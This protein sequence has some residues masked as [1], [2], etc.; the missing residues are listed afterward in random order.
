MTLIDF[1]FPKLR[2]CK[3]QS[4]KCLK[5][6]PSEY[7]STR[8]IADVPK[9]CEICITGSFSYYLIL[10]KSIELEKVSLIDICK[11]LGLLVNTFAA[12]EK[13]PVVSKDN[14]TIPIQMQS[15]QKQNTFLK[16]FA[17]FLKSSLNFGYFEKKYEPHRFCLSESNDS[18]NLV[19]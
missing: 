5:I 16:F 6:P 19:K 18:E 17:A 7:P 14:L 3:T 11:I 8:N 10:A 9:H 4:D 15:S 13:Y 2:T 1:I 12:D